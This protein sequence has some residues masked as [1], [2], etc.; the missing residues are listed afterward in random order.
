MR[1]KKDILVGIE[2]EQEMA[3]AAIRA[4]KRAEQDLPAEEPVNQLHFEDMTTLLKYLSPR[5]FELLQKLR[6]IGPLNIRKLSQALERDYKNVYNDVTDL[7]HIGL[8]EE[9]KD[10]RFCVPWDE[11]LARLPLLAKAM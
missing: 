7:T 8:I 1:K 3:E 5:R 6:M 4:W 9:T 10:R 11:I 2:S